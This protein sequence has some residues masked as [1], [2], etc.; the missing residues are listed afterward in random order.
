MTSHYVQQITL[1]TQVTENVTTCRKMDIQ[2]NSDFQ[3]YFMIDAMKSHSEV[4]I[5]IFTI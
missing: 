3:A 1:S 2:L 4:Q 5:T